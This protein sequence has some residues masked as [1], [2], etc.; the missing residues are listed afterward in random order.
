MF[1]II[2]YKVVE[3]LYRIISEAAIGY[4]VIYSQH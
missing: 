4:K 2:N 3:I 1:F